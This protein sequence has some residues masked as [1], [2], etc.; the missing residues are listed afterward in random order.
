V[1]GAL[2]KPLSISFSLLSRPGSSQSGFP[3][4]TFPELSGA[5]P[6]QW[7]DRTDSTGDVPDVGVGVLD[8]VRV[9]ELLREGELVS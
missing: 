8:P 3:K 4:F 2:L 9:G 5:F 7:A 6:P 1:P